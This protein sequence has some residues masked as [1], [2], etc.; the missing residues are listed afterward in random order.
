[1]RDCTRTGTTTKFSVPDDKQPVY[2]GT[3]FSVW[4]SPSTRALYVICDDYHAGL[5]EMPVEELSRLLASLS[6]AGP[7]SPGG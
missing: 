7:Q 3:A 4:F 2:A 1:M 5:I 6:G